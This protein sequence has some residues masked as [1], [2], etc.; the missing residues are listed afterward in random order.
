MRILKK[1]TH[2]VV[3]AVIIAVLASACTKQTPGSFRLKQQEES[4][5]LGEEINTQVDLLWVIDNSPSMNVSQERLRK[6]IVSFSQKYLKPNWDIQL[7]VTTMDTYLA[8]PAFK[9]Y[10]SRVASYGTPLKSA[11][12]QSRLPHLDQSQTKF[13]LSMVDAQTG[14]FKRGIHVN[15]QHPLWNADYALLKAGIHDGPSPSLCWEKDNYFFNSPNSNCR[16]R[17]NAADYKGPEHC[18]RP[19]GNE[20][21]ATQCVNT[22]FNDSIHSGEAILHTLAPGT[23][24]GD[25]WNKALIDKFLVNVT[26]G[27]AGEGSQRGFS[28]LLQTLKDNSGTSSALFRAGALHI[29]VFVSDEDDQSMKLPETPASSFSPFVDYNRPPTQGTCAP[30]TVDGY[31]Y[32]L[33]RCA[34]PEL[35]LPVDS[36][37]TAAPG[38]KQQLDNYFTLLN[39]GGAPDYLVA[40]IVPIKGQTI[41]ALHEIRKI[42][43]ITGKNTGQVTVDRGDRFLQLSTLADQGSPI[44]MDIGEEDYSPILNDVGR[45]ITLRISQFEVKRLPTNTEEMMVTVVRGN[46][47]STLLSSD[48]FELSGKVLKLTDTDLILSLGAADRIV[49]NYQPKTVY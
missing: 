39:G 27:T 38:M 47:Q 25:A 24:D 37:D 29:I 1:T 13:D 35:L 48:Q 3:A 46:G 40:S 41:S 43:D 16:V 2:P 28:S 45:A 30:K 42:D 19:T 26:V 33:T 36:T 4:F 11:Y 31:T 5:R 12:I 23:A 17:D 15:E 14:V 6:G 44:A 32:T 10:T 9:G 49:I 22:V 18:I 7:A 20:N 8:N 21:V 34:K